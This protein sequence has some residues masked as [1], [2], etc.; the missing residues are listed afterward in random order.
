MIRR[1][2]PKTKPPS[3]KFLDEIAW[4]LFILLLGASWIASSY[5]NPDTGIYLALGT[6]LIL[7]A[8]NLV[9]R[10]MGIAISI[11]T[12]ILIDT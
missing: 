5:F 9:R 1:F 10:T 11:R 3:N 12:L 7:I 8:L 6:G 4:G 2:L